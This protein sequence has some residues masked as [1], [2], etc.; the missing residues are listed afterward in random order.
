MGKSKK[1]KSKTINNLKDQVTSKLNEEGVIPLEEIL[2]AM[3][4]KVGESIVSLSYITA[5]LQHGDESR[6]EMMDEERYFP[7]M[8]HLSSVAYM[9]A[10]L[11]YDYNTI[12]G[13]LLHMQKT[14][15]DPL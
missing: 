14:V 6:N 3:S 13:G 4:D 2:L 7:Y 10:M 9:L 11:G 5:Q 15:V 8:N 12:S 1:K